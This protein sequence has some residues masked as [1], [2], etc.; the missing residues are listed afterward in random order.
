MRIFDDKKGLERGLIVIT[1]LIILG[2]GIIFIGIYYSNPYKA[3]DKEACRTSIILRS[4]PIMGES[5]KAATPLNCRTEE[6]KID[7][8]Y[9]TEEQ[10]KKKVADA[11]AECWSMVGKGEMNFMPQEFWT[12]GYCLVCDVIKFDEKTRNNFPSFTGLLDYM[13]KTEMPLTKKTY[14]NYIYDGETN[15]PSN[16]DVDID[17]SQDYAILFSLKKDGWLKSNPDVVGAI[18]IGT[19]AV[20]TVFTAGAAAPVMA[21]IVAVEQTAAATTITAVSVSS[22]TAII[23]GAAAAGAAKLALGYVGGKY[24]MNKIGF[25]RKTSVGEAQL[26][27]MPYTKKEI[28]KVCTRFENAP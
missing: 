11:M 19:A 9:R 15:L 2:A 22:G 25:F 21:T 5:F 6:I 17:T 12:E 24:L 23:G 3:V 10:I 27:L 18:V 16:F 7:K 4:T 8:S 14:Y 26:Y 28:E 13:N 1:I 20:I